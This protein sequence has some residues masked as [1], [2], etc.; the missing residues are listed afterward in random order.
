MGASDLGGNLPFR[1]PGLGKAI[2]SASPVYFAG[3]FLDWENR[4]FPRVVRAVSPKGSTMVLSEGVR[5]VSSV[6]E[7]SVSYG[8]DRRF[9]MAERGAPEAVDSRDGSTVGDDGRYGRGL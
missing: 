3:I 6:S 1:D 7:S 5:I 8:V 2:T 9:P 4:L